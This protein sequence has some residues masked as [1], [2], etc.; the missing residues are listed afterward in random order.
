MLAGVL[1]PA[2]TGVQLVSEML[3]HREDLLDRVR[4]LWRVLLPGIVAP[5]EFERLRGL[6]ELV[7]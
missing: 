6:P 1:V 7:R 5:S 2:Y 3:T 4:D